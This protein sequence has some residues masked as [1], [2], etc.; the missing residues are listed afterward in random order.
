MGVESEDNI[1]F[2]KGPS[3][4]EGGVRD[5]WDSFCWSLCSRGDI[6]LTMFHLPPSSTSIKF[7]NLFVYILACNINM[8]YFSRMFIL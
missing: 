4:V 6:T 2:F 8:V 5:E 1:W 7:N 3:N